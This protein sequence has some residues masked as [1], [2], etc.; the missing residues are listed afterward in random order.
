M[1]WKL[2]FTYL[3]FITGIGVMVYGHLT[4]RNFGDLIIIIGSLIILS[5]GV[6]FKF[7]P[8]TGLKFH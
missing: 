8:K 6:T 4:K 5:T 1:N 7:E 3:K 2:L